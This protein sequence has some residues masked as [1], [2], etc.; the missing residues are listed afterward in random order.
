MPAIEHVVIAAAGIG[1][2]LGHGIPKC[3]VELAGRSLIER[4]L[5]LLSHIADIRVVVGYMEQ[6]VMDAVWRVNQNVIVVRNPNYRETTTQDSYALGADGLT[7]H[8]LFLDADIIFESSSF[9]QFLDFAAPKDLAIGVTAAKTDNAVF[10]VTRPSAQGGLEI[11]SFSSEP[12]E[13]EWANVVWAPAQAFLRRG[14]PVF[15]RLQIW[16]PAP[17]GV[18]VSYEIDT[19]QDLNRA[20]E[21]LR[22]NP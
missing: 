16:L 1:S 12:A 14:G 18:I 5:T 21:F 8:C 10:A 13:F 7:G 19:E 2:R 15:E 11:M 4:Q 20:Q 3:L 6:T 9:H 22:I 17:A